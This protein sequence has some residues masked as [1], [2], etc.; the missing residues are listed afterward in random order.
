MGM[1]HEITSRRTFL[2]MGSGVSLAAVLAACGSNNGRSGGGGGG[3]GD[4]PSLA[5]WYH[6]YGEAGTEQAVQRYAAQYKKAKVTV[7]WTPGDYD[8][9][10][11]AALL[12]SSGPDVFEAGNGPTATAFL[13]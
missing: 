13:D 4:L 8:K 3:G 9:K 11:A 7:T 1:S 6:Q 12:T 2:A 5:Q 10:A